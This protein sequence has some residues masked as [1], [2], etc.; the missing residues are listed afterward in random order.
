MTHAAAK[1]EEKNQWARTV[2]LVQMLEKQDS[3]F[4]SDSWQRTGAVNVITWNA[5]YSAIIGKPG[6]YSASA[7]TRHLP[8]LCERHGTVNTRLVLADTVIYVVCPRNLWAS[9]VLE[10]HENP[11]L[12]RQDSKDN[13]PVTLNACPTGSLAIFTVTEPVDQKTVTT[14]MTLLALGHVQ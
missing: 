6:L 2:T 4:A 5:V 1:P 13:T 3:N 11:T 8:P 10:L 14:A 9:W 12:A 7:N